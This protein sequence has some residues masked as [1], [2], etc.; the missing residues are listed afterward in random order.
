VVG[1]SQVGGQLCT[2]LLAHGV[3]VIDIERKPNAPLWASPQSS[4][5][6]VVIGS[7]SAQ[8]VWST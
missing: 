2:N 7:G 6:A 4:A 8:E 3:P 5:S 1:M